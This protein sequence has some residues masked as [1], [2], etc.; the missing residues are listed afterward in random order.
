MP[1]LEDYNTGMCFYDAAKNNADIIEY[2]SIFRRINNSNA[3][4]AREISHENT[5]HSI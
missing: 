2:H 3:C 5:P 4:I 1:V